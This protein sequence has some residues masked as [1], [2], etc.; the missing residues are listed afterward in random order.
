MV[1]DFHV[2]A[3]NPKIAERAVSTFENNC[4]ITA[5][6]RGLVEQTAERFDE[7]GVDKGVLLSIATKPSQQT[8]INDWAKE[9]DGGRFISFGGIHPDA[10]DVFDEIKRIK[11]LGLHGIKL[12][13]DYQNFYVDE[14]RLDDIYDAIE[15]VDLPVL[16]HSGFDGFSPDIVHCTP[17]RA[18]KMITKHK[19]LKVVFAHLGSNELWQEVYDTLAG[20][21]GEV[22]FDTGYT[23]RC[24][25]GLME[26]II[27]KHGTDRILFASDCPW[28]S[29]G[30]IKQKIERLDLSSS[31]IEKIL[32]GN[33]Q[34]LLNLQG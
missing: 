30:K 2:H 23:L 26:K 19:N 8:I 5:Y 20:V 11:D 1:I 6:T 18:L 10:A 33:A 17:E 34:R 32:G 31:D 16:I 3:Y 22:Y 29:S 14:E 15:K 9:Q 12:H 24:S 25:D 27:K 4:G 21:D 7:W 28:Q 13:P